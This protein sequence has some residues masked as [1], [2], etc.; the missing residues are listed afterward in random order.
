MAYGRVNCGATLT[1]SNWVTQID[2]SGRE[3]G[4][5][6]VQN[7]FGNELVIRHPH[8]ATTAWINLFDLAGKQLL[9]IPLDTSARKTSLSTG[10][11]APG[12]YLIS[13]FSSGGI[14]FSQK[15]IKL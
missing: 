9:E 2:Q 13:V 1:A 14:L 8:L 4:P 10:T 12:I 11:L 7:P 5:F 6:S 15:V 3:A